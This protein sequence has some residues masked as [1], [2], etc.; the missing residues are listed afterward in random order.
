M[1][2]VE[3]AGIYLSKP[4]TYILVLIYL[5]QS[6]LLIFLVHD[7]FNLEKTIGDQHTQIEKMQEKMRIFKVIEDFSDGFNDE[8]KRKLTNVILSECDKY[9][10]DPLFFMGLILTES[11]LRRG[12]VSNKGAQGLMQV[13]PF[14]GRSLADESGVEWVND[15]TLFDVEANIRIGS[16]HLFRQILQFESV[17]KGLVAYNHGETALRRR[18]RSDKPMPQKY[19]KKVFSKYQ[20]LK[21]KYGKPS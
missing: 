6:G 15:E 9:G 2:H 7:K 5:A 3:K 17:D 16:L 12:Q 18:L 10:Y 8:E 13:M 19:L 11:S 20:E 14:V 21:E 1:I 4:I